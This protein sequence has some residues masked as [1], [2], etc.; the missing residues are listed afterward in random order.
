MCNSITARHTA[1]P[2]KDELVNEEEELHDSQG[3]EAVKYGH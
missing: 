2:H 3:H 1:G